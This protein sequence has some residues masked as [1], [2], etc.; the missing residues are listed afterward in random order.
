MKVLRIQIC[1]IVI[2]LNSA[3]ASFAENISQSTSPQA[4]FKEA[5]ILYDSGN[6]Q[7]AVSVLEALL[8]NPNLT[9][10]EK[11]AIYSF[12]LNI[13]KYTINYSKLSSGLKAVKDIIFDGTYFTKDNALQK[14]GVL[15][16]YAYYTSFLFVW[17]GNTKS[18]IEFLEKAIPK[19]KLN[20]YNMSALILVRSQLALLQ[21][22]EGN[23]DEADR[24]M[25]E[26]VILAGS[27]K[28]LDKK[29]I[30]NL[31]MDLAIYLNDT[32]RTSLAYQI[33]KAID[34]GSRGGIKNIKLFFWDLLKARIQLE[35]GFM[36]DCYKTIQ[37]AEG[38]INPDLQIPVFHLI[39]KN[40]FKGVCGSF[41]GKRKE[42]DSTLNEFDR[43]DPNNLYSELTVEARAVIYYLKG[44]MSSFQKI[45]GK[46][47]IN[48]ELLE[49]NPT[50]KEFI[51]E[52]NHALK[53][54]YSISLSRIKANDGELKTSSTLLLNAIRKHI[55]YLNGEIHL[56]T[57]TKFNFDWSDRYILMEMLDLL[58][59]HKSSDQDAALIFK[60]LQYINHKH[61]NTGSVLK[62]ITDGAETDIEKAEFRS[63]ERLTYHFNHLLRSS[64]WKVVDEGRNTNIKSDKITWD[65]GW[66]DLYDRFHQIIKKLKGKKEILNKLISAGKLFPD[67]PLVQAQLEQDEVIVMP[68]FLKDK[69]FITCIEKFDSHYVTTKYSKP[70]VIELIKSVRESLSSTS[71]VPSRSN[72][73]PFDDSAALYNMIFK[74]ISSCLDKKSHIN[75]IPDS[76]L[77]NLPYNALITKPINIGSKPNAF[78]EAPWLIRNHSVSL[79]P[80][81]KSFYMLRQLA[82]MPSGQK[83]FLGFGKSQFGKNNN[84]SL[85]IAENEYFL[86]GINPTKSLNLLA[87]LPETRNEINGIAEIFSPSKTKVYLDKEASELNL[88]KENLNDYK[89]IS[90]ATHALMGGES[91]LTWEPALIFTS[92]DTDNSL[93]DGIVTASEISALSLNANLVILS[94]CNT[95]SSDG[96]IDGSRLSGLANSFFLAGARSLAITQWPVYSKMAEVITTRMVSEGINNSIGVAE[97]LR[98]T[99]LH[100]IKN[101]IKGYNSHP[102]Y[103]A[104]FIIAGNGKQLI[105]ANVLP[106]ANKVLNFPWMHYSDIGSRGEFV[107]HD[108]TRNLF[109]LSGWSSLIANNQIRKVPFIKILTKSGDTLKSKSFQDLHGGATSIRKVFKNKIAILGIPRTKTDPSVQLLIMDKDLDI[110]WKYHIKANVDLFNMGMVGDDDFVYLI[111]H[112]IDSRKNIPEQARVP[113]SISI[114]KINKKGELVFSNRFFPKDEF[115]SKISSIRAD[116]HSSSFSATID[117]GNVVFVANYKSKAPKAK[118]TDPK[119][120]CRKM[121]STLISLNAETLLPSKELYFKNYQFSSIK[122]GPDDLFYLIGNH[123]KECG[124]SLNL[125]IIRGDLEKGFNP[126]FTFESP[127]TQFGG[128]IIFYKDKIIAIGMTNFR[129]YPFLEFTSALQSIKNSISDSK[130]L[131]KSI[132]VSGIKSLGWILLV[133]SNGK[134]LKDKIIFDNRLSSILGLDVNSKG[135]GIA[136]GV[137]NGH[138]LLEMGFSLN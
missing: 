95:F 104:P 18:A 98:R 73:F 76:L 87:A 97:S 5:E 51:K 100:L 82:N 66:L 62:R 36:E 118:N 111:L 1:L 136:T 24:R 46:D 89:I 133:D 4:S 50:K 71:A 37:V 70:K 2:L 22:A 83:D 15:Y 91:D 110:I 33:I 126:F 79:I 84:E 94:A 53:I 63:F 31:L 122:K 120:N 49:D 44:G 90:F 28:G 121:V 58:F 109:Y 106:Q 27:A 78:L 60:T 69:L 125:S 12:L 10:E 129:F 135:E 112:N 30:G 134:L 128:D 85:D 65:N 93:D 52:N 39:R 35:M 21:L 68:T 43:L 138:Q 13:Y 88:R 114:H 3:H 132:A 127:L 117:E 81:V 6:T 101:P 8:S 26:A 14:S 108:N 16:A 45:V 107:I 42:L 115:G 102:K 67:L 124:S 59:K 123:Q 116:R 137:I 19:I 7:K 64:A 40:Y 119:N 131:E 61:D 75:I 9:R 96:S 32:G 77:L 55:D 47:F 92:G 41:A 25:A 23:N 48:S 17:E 56:S 11:L 99:M 74:P 57:H 54:I 86:R 105:G 72:F 20:E 29:I 113:Y 103:W 38:Y 80:S 34:T 130:W